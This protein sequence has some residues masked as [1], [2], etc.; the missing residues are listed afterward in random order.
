M[1]RAD[2]DAIGRTACMPA[3]CLRR[4]RVNSVAPGDPNLCTNRGSSAC[5]SPARAF[6]SRGTSEPMSSYGFV[7]EVA[8]KLGQ[9]RSPRVPFHV[10]LINTPRTN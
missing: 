1:Q 6:H 10:K 8:N 9:Q 2:C 7:G 5:C 3:S 4:T